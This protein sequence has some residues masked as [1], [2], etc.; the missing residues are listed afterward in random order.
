MKTNKEKRNQ[1]NGHTRYIKY[2]LFHY[3]HR[4]YFLITEELHERQLRPLEQTCMSDHLEP[5]LRFLGSHRN[6]RRGPTTFV[7]LPCRVLLGKTGK[8]SVSHSSAN[9]HARSGHIPM[10]PVGFFV[11]CTHRQHRTS[12]FRLSC[13]A[14]C[15]M[16]EQ[17]L[18]GNSPSLR[19]G[20]DMQRTGLAPLLCNR[21]I[22][23][24]QEALVFHFQNCY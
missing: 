11:S 23:H 15:L 12:D 18:H 17:C 2:H 20:E 16:A 3:L 22:K 13:S 24:L 5:M 14:F 9:T 19:P 1:R 6:E 4:G 7:F 10:L 21:F 8:T